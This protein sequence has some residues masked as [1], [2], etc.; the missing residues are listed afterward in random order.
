MLNANA[1]GVLSSDP[2]LRTTDYGDVCNFS[3][4]C[5][6]SLDLATGEVTQT[7]VKAAAWGGVA[8]VVAATL[9]KGSAVAI[10]G[11]AKVREWIGNDGTAGTSLDV[12]VGGWH[13]LAAPPTGIYGLTLVGV[14]IITGAAESTG[15]VC[16]VPVGI[17]TGR[18]GKLETSE[19]MAMVRETPDNPQALQQVFVPGSGIYLAGHARLHTG[20]LELTPFAWEVLAG[21]PRAAL[22]HAPAPESAQ[23]RPRANPTQ[24]AYQVPPGAPF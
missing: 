22:P 3:L 16:H 19:V 18:A 9:A 14:G 23:V 7:L 4:T 13:A 5:C 2:E 21:A 12:S 15:Q 11:K 1:I 10:A 24:A 6:S 17:E 8:P 20:R